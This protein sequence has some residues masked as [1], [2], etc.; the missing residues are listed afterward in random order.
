MKKT[1]SA[2]KKTEPKLRDGDPIDYATADRIAKLIGVESP[3]T[4]EA[5]DA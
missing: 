4:H 3:V 1:K 5:R 2:K